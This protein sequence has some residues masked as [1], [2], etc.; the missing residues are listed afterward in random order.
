MWGTRNHFLLDNTVYRMSSKRKMDYSESSITL[1]IALILKILFTP[2]LDSTMY[3]DTTIP[4][5]QQF[6]HTLFVFIVCTVVLCH[7]RLDFDSVLNYM[8]SYSIT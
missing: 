4:D 6:I 7:Y 5:D 8:P 3:R 1:P 2:T